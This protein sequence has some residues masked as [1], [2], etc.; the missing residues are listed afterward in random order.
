MGRRI[1]S[2]QRNAASGRT[3]QTASG[4]IVTG[5]RR[6]ERAAAGAV[7]RIEIAGPWELA[8]MVALELDLRHVA[9]RHGAAV[10]DFRVEM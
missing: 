6:P 5:K 3:P 4:R 9:R 7:Y 1:R 8:A 10:E 2:G